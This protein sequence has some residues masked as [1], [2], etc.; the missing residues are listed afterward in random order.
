MFKHRLLVKVQSDNLILDLFKIPVRL[1]RVVMVRL[2]LFFFFGLFFFTLFDDF[3][4]IK[5]IVIVVRFTS[6]IDS[7]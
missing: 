4:Q 7:Q 5:C 1:P 3:N 2:G 6:W